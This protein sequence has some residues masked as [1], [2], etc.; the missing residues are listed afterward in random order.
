MLAM[1]RMTVE[2]INKTLKDR[3]RNRRESLDIL[4]YGRGPISASR[5]LSKSNEL[6]VIVRGIFVGFDS[7]QPICQLVRL[8]DKDR[9][10][11]WADIQFLAL[12]FDHDKRSFLFGGAAIE[13]R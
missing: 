4:P 7:R 8:V 6:P 1:R 3:T 11:L 9:Q 13:T 5:L 10:A 2:T 12:E